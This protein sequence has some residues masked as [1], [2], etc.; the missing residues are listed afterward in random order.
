MK[1]Y[2]GKD[3]KQTGTTVTPSLERGPF[4]DPGTSRETAAS[5]MEASASTSEVQPDPPIYLIYAASGYSQYCEIIDFSDSEVE[6]L[7]LQ[8]ALLESSSYTNITED[9]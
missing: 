6:D 2:V 4:G 1:T 8:E 7:E 9:R 3:F 5:V